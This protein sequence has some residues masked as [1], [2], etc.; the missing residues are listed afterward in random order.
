MNGNVRIVGGEY[1]QQGAWPWAVIIGRAG[2]TGFSV[3]C[4]GSLVDADT[5]LT[6]AHCFD[7]VPGLGGPTTV[8]LGEHDIT[9]TL[10]GAQ[11][12]DV[13]IEKI[14]QH[15]GWNPD[16]L[17][18]DIAVVKLNKNVS[19]TPDIQTVCLPDQYVGKELE[20]V[21]NTPE[22]VVVGWGATYTYGG[23]ETKLRQTTVSVVTKEDC[24]A[25]YDGVNVDI[26]DT[27][28][29][30]GKG[31]RDTCNGDSGGPLL[32][33]HLGDD[34]RWSIVG[35]TSFGVDCGRPDFPGVYT[36]VDKYLEW[37]RDKM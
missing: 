14:I 35:I 28:V 37:I 12:V 4:G 13:A 23:A 29:C 34:H 10:D 1:A 27:K 31:E 24:R 5:I 2:L 7:R 19:L 21:I 6:A 3:I 22:P 8:R 33:D 11:H 26:G 32:A 25:A 17:D 16:T 20:V 18:N 36:R 15:P 9:T 30:A